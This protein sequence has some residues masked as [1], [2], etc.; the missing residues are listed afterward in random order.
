MRSRPYSNLARLCDHYLVPCVLRTS[1]ECRLCIGATELDLC[2]HRETTP[3]S[4]S[5]YP[6]QKENFTDA[7]A[8]GGYGPL[9]R[10]SGRLGASGPLHPT[11]VIERSTEH[12]TSCTHHVQK[13]AQSGKLSNTYTD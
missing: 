6:S 5:K 1:R 4:P 13:I 8:D 9:R 10:A 12:T 11:Q 3:T 2:T 7:F